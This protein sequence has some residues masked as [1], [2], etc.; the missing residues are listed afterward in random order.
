MAIVEED[1]VNYDHEHN[2][3]ILQ[4]LNLEAEDI[5]RDLE[6][7]YEQ[8]GTVKQERQQLADSRQS[9]AY[10]LELEE[11]REG[12]RRQF[13]QWAA[14]QT[15]SRMLEAT[16]ASFERECQPC[17]LADASEYLQ[18]LTCGRY[19]RV[20]T[21][22]GERGLRLEDGHRR[23]WLV[24]DVSNG[25]REQL[26]LAI[27]LAI[28]DEFERQGVSLPLVLD[29]VIVNFD[30]QRTEAAL[31]V[32]TDYAERRQQILFFTC[33]RHIVERLAH[34]GIDAINLPSRASSLVERQAG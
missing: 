25:T 2:S 11:A 22:L 23:N 5:E 34:R 26:F 33:H 29:D 27:R 15:A 8:L 7:A 19:N 32:L 30:E 17:T 9:A 12:L 20:W 3:G 16:C 4:M 18:P 14:H 10:R 21:P 6:Q 24:G 13:F 28:I 1:L 31:S